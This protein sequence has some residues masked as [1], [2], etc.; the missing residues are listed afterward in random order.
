MKAKIKINLKKSLRIFI[1]S[2]RELLVSKWIDSEQRLRPF[3][4]WLI[5]T[6]K[7]PEIQVTRRN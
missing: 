7:I 3:Q 2:M 1:H 4:K 6:Q 5:N